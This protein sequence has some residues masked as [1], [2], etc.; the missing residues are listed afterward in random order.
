[1]NENTVTPQVIENN[2]C[3]I[4]YHQFC[5]TT[6]TVCCVTMK[7]GFTVTGQSA[8][9]DPDNFDSEIGEALALEDA[10]SK[11]WSFLGFRLKDQLADNYN[12][13]TPEEAVYTVFDEDAYDVPEGMTRDEAFQVM[14]HLNNVDLDSCG[15]FS[16]DI[17]KKQK[18]LLE[19]ALDT[20]I[21]TDEEDLAEC[22]PGCDDKKQPDTSE[23]VQVY[24][25]VFDF[26]KAKVFE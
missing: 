25:V 23:D 14:I 16:S 22:G 6:T 21:D 20:L 18:V 12:L 7:N 17:R 24:E 3:A 9:A 8:C 1:M 26:S 2:I 19:Q 5:G 10:K 4:Q 11:M 13:P 15:A